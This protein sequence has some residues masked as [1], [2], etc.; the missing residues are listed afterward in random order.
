MAYWHWSSFA[1]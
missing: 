1:H